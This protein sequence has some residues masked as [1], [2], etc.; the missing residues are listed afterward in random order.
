MP[1]VNIPL[2]TLT[3]NEVIDDSVLPSL[4]QPV[5]SFSDFHLVVARNVGANSLDNLPNNVTAIQIFGEWSVDGNNWF[6]G[7]SAACPG[8]PIFA[9]KAQTIRIETFEIDW[10]FGPDF[11]SANFIRGRVVNGPNSASV[12]GSAT[13]S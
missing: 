10:P 3:A 2:T 12:S 7:I 8:G 11:P 6:P 5:G 13:L 9:D 1:S 4:K